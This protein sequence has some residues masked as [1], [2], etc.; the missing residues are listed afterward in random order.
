MIKTDGKITQIKGT[1]SKVLAE[2][3]VTIEAVFKETAE[4]VGEERAKELVKT[5]Y[6]RAFMSEKEPEEEVEKARKNILAML[7]GIGL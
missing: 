7:K 4:E 2:L 1:K 6:E 5:A 3:A